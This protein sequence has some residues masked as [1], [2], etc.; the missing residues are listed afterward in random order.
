M[1]PIGAREATIDRPP[2][3]R[4]RGPGLLTGEAGRQSRAGQARARTLCRD[5][6]G[7]CGL[8][9]RASIVGSVGS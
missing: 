1:S 4:D 7:L 5:I 9:R 2:P 3:A 8:A 6:L